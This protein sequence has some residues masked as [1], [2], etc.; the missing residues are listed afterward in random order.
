[1]RLDLVRTI[2]FQSAWQ[3]ETGG[4][5]RYD[6]PK[7]SVNHVEA[8]ARNA[9]KVIN[10]RSTPGSRSG[11]MLADLSVRQKRYGTAVLHYCCSQS[12]L[13]S[14]VRLAFPIRSM[15]QASQRRKGAVGSKPEWAQG[16]SAAGT[17]GP[18]VAWTRTIMNPSLLSP[19]S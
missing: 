11:A 16:S 12:T 13:N 10:S 15:R 2:Q 17:I 18:M 7:Q 14:H 4:K 9:N 1:M 19:D 6:W 5:A 3:S 8:Q